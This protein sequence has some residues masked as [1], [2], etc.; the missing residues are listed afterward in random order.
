MY[1]ITIKKIYCL[2]IFD[3][4]QNYY[5]TAVIYLTVEFKF[6]LLVMKNAFSGENLE[7]NNYAAF[8]LPDINIFEANE[9]TE[10]NF[11]KISKGDF[12]GIK[13]YSKNSFL[14]NNPNNSP[15]QKNS[16]K[17]KDK[18]ET[19]FAN[20]RFPSILLVTNNSVI[21]ETTEKIYLINFKF[22][23]ISILINKTIKNEIKII[24]TYDENVTL[25]YNQKTFTRSYVFCLD[26]LKRLHFFFLED[27]YVNLKDKKIILHKMPYAGSDICDMAIIYMTNQSGGGNYFFFVFLNEKSIKFFVTDYYENNLG[28]ILNSLNFKKQEIKLDNPSSNS[29]KNSNNNENNMN[30]NYYNNINNLNQNT[31]NLI[32][33]NNLNLKDNA[34][35]ASIR[36]N[37]DNLNK[38]GGK[39]LKDRVKKI[40]SIGK[41]KLKT[42][43]K[44]ESGIDFSNIEIAFDQDADIKRIFVNEENDF[45]FVSFLTNFN[46]YTVKF[47]SNISPWVLAEKFNFMLLIK[48]ADNKKKF[49]KLSRIFGMKKILTLDISKK[50]TIEETDIDMNFKNNMILSKYESQGEI[51]KSF[52]YFLI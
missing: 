40:L 25:S 1:S 51:I 4:T 23:K 8:K 49:H 33:S 32:N 34:N 12:N 21:L 39:S 46:L 37:S 26:K 14:K 38:E 42:K 44:P 5:F 20:Y 41:F 19:V 9:K 3:F 27:N 47:E 22:S 52:S 10:E 31:S 28:L 16:I 18:S 35:K 17:R 29:N 30:I 15:T 6:E 36:E 7:L 45:V 50:E 2:V 13:F 48:G 43:A 24:Y 11:D